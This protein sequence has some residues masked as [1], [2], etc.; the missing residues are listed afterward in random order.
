M[1]SEPGS[2]SFKRR[3]TALYWIVTILFLLNWGRLIIWTCHAWHGLSFDARF[4]V[5]C[6]LSVFPAP[7]LVMAFERQI[8]LLFLACC[9]YVALGFSVSLVFLR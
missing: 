4:V 2:G 5:A 1:D 6:L 9:S 7:W 3:E 8:K